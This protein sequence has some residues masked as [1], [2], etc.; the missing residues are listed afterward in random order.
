V[1]RSSDTLAADLTGKREIVLPAESVLTFNDASIS[2]SARELARLPRAEEKTRAY[3]QDPDEDEE[4]DSDAY[5]KRRRDRRASEDYKTED[6][7]AEDGGKRGEREYARHEDEH[8][9][10]AHLGIPQGHLPPPGECRIWIPGR[11]PGHQ[12]PP[13]PCGA[14]L[15][16]PPGGWLLRRDSDAKHVR[17]SV[18]DTAQ[19]GIISAIRVYIAATGRFV[20]EERH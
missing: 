7:E 13:Q 16:V 18:Y 14:G 19:S 2:A 10:Y 6:H 17:V 8:R 9:E 4:L 15:R 11:P 20:R 12:P 1:S 3:R 5:S